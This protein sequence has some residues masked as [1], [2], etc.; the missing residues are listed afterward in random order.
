MKKIVYSA[1]LVLAAVVLSNCGGGGGEAPA[2][3][4]VGNTLPPSTGPGDVENF[5]PGTPGTSWNYFATATD[6]MGGV[7]STHIDTLTVTGTKNIGG[8]TA[9][10]FLESNP[11][12]TGLPVEGYYLKNA[13]GVAFL[14]TNDPTDT[15]NAAIAPYIVALFPVTSGEV[16]HFD[17][18]GID[19]GDDL[20]GDGIN[21][22][23]NLT[24]TSTILGFEPL[25]IGIGSFP[26]TAKSR[27][28]VSGSVMLSGLRISV[29]FSTSMTRWSAPGI[30]VVKTQQSVTVESVTS[31][32][33]MEARG[34]TADGVAHGFG[35]PFTVASNLPANLLP[36]VDPPALASDG[37]NFLAAS[38]NASG[39]VAMLFG[40]NGTPITSV[41]VTAG[42]GSLFPVASFDGANYWVLF[43]PYS[44]GTSGGV[45]TCFA[46]RVSPTGMLLDVADLTLATVAGPYVSI[47]STALAFG[48]TNGL[49]VLSQFNNTT[50]QHHLLGALVN[51][52]G[53]ASA[54]FPIA[55]DDST[56][57]NPAVAFDGT[58]FFVTWTQ[59]ATSGATVGSIHGIRVSAAGTVLDPAPIAISTAPNGQSNPSVA[60][61]GTNY[62]VTWLDLRNQPTLIGPPNSDIY[63]ARVSMAGVLLD[64]PPASGGFMIDGGGSIQRTP[65][66]V[67]FLG[68]E[69]LVAWSNL[70][71]SNSGLLGVRAARV[72]TAGTLPSGAGRTIPVIGPPVAGLATQPASVVM[73]SG[74]QHGALIWFDDQNAAKLLIGASFSP[75]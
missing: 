37:Q 46:R 30:G 56:H 29:P 11:S 43:T 61:D 35:L 31:G 50:S 54:P 8:Q 32:E 42:T 39:L 68:N 66:H 72:S 24:L 17:K 69:Y 63:G 55:V 51:P 73:A 22:S 16:A 52:D 36:V 57:I 49:L 3:T 20:D 34:Y 10:V 58:N 45:I 67:I 75:F 41:N 71:F 70:G 53:T 48:N 4:G 25:S 12:G 1:L 27:E 59:L 47:S 26:R 14:G 62:L 6:P 23:V 13:G 40:S 28:A 19:F 2:S 74:A 18:N 5:F 33:A 65:P 64:G 38:E 21:E 7:V 15:L 60:F 44:G 9:A